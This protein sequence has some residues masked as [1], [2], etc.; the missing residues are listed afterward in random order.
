MVTPGEDKPPKSFVSATAS[1][2]GK[3]DFQ[4][5]VSNTTCRTGQSADATGTCQFQPVR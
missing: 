4:K 1:S 5:L 3:N 2:A